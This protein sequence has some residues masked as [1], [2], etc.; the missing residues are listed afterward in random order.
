MRRT[1]GWLLLGAAGGLVLGPPPG[2]SAAAAS[3]ALGEREREE[4][5][6]VGRRSVA[7]DEFGTEW[8]V[9]DGAGQSALVMTPFH[10]V[11]LEARK[12]AFK[13][14]PLK[15]KDVDEALKAT[16][17]KLTFWVTLKGGRPDF[18]RHYAPILRNGKG[19]I[20]PTFVQNERT[21]L[22]DEDGRFAA[23]CLYVF[24]TEGVTGAS[25]LTLLVR[26]PDEKEMAKFT[27]D[28]SGMR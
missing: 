2:P 6:R 5:I 10:R 7:L 8:R 11:A 15:P 25:R 3:L 22:R 20:T 23:R 9:R 24:P 1:I 21:A 4:A 12:S 26:D 27:V 19:E 14:Q 28:L 16:A 13:R 18:A 17:G